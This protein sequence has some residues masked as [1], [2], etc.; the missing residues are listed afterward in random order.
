MIPVLTEGLAPIILNYGNILPVAHTHNTIFEM[1]IRYGLLGTI[2]FLLLLISIYKKIEDPDMKYL[3]LLLLFLSLFQV[4]IRDF[5][6]LFFLY[7][8][9]I[10]KQHYPMRG[11]N[12]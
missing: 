3:F 5:N 4:F 9:S 6:F 8:L 1:L 2:P 12:E 7:V 10:G 11:N